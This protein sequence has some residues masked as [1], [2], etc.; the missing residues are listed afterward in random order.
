[1]RTCN[2]LVIALI[3]SISTQAAELKSKITAVKLY[4][5]QA[6]VTRVVTLNLKSGENKFV[7]IGLPPILYDWSIKGKL[8]GGFN[9]KILSMQVQKKALLERRQKKIAQ[10]E[11]KLEG[12]KEKDQEL[13]DDLRNIHSQDQ[14]LNSIITFTNQTVAKELMTR[15]PQVKV[16]DNTLNYVSA[17]RKKLATEKRKTEKA[18]EDIGKKIQKWEFDLA[19]LAGRRYFRQYQSWNKAVFSNRAKLATQEFGSLNEQYT[20][21]QQLLSAPGGQIE[22]EKRLK[23]SIFSPKNSQ[24]RFEFSYIVPKANWRMV[25]DVRAHAKAQSIDFLVYADLAQQTGED[26]SEVDLLLS[27]GAPQN[28]LSPPTLS[29]WYLSLWSRTSGKKRVS[30]GLLSKSTDSAPA[31]GSTGE[32]IRKIPQARIKRKGPA[33]EIKLPLK[34]MITSSTERQKKFIK[35]HSFKSKDTVSFY[36]EI[37]PQINSKSFIKTKITNRTNLPFLSGQAQLFL[38]SEFMGKV[39][40]PYTPVGKS[41]DIILGNDDR[42]TAKKTLL[43]RY[44]DSAGLFGGNRR[45]KYDYKIEIENNTP[46]T[47]EVWI[48]DAIPVARNEKI[49]V[50][51]ANKSMDFWHDAEFKKS[52]EYARGIRK[53]RVIMLKGGRHQITYQVVITFD[54]KASVYGLR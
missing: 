10:L 23:V 24:V 16:W 19:Q 38:D 2:A 32:V 31:S 43:K 1:M 3:S 30:K 25:Y 48:V 37:T 49:K 12:L 53:W 9:A 13:L 47:A 7:L 8:P 5:N 21:K 36:Y 50:E 33:V 27:T 17:K 29:S 6:N 35:E 46:K 26:W 44:E 34:Q 42:I 22:T 14:F 51:I 40:I 20:R 15:T 52:T 28:Q 4:Q 54:K 45:I 41:R 18:R 39:N 11:K